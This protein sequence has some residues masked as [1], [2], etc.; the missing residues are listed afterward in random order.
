MVEDDE[1]VYLSIKSYNNFLIAKI[2]IAV[3][4]P[5]RVTEALMKRLVQSFEILKET[6]VEIL[7][8]LQT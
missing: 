6:S 1:K 4:E 7:Q 3:R 8:S 2:R 5:Q